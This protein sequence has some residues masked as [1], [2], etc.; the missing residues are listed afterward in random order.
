MEQCTFDNNAYAIECNSGSRPFVNNCIIWN[1]KNDNFYVNGDAVP[2]ISFS[3]IDEDELDYSIRSKGGNIYNQDPKFMNPS[4]ED[5]R[6]R[7][8]SP[9]IKKGAKSKDMGFLY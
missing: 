4:Y 8:D 5:Y 9:C 1:S 3:C 6:L 7:K 2:T